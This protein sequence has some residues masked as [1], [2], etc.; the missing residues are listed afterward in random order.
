[1]AQRTTRKLAQHALTWIARIHSHT[2]TNTVTTTLCKGGGA[3]HSTQRKNPA[4]RYHI[5]EEKIQCPRLELN[6]NPPT[7]VI[8]SLGQEHTASDP[9]SY[10][11]LQNHWLSFSYLFPGSKY[12]SNFM[13]CAQKKEKAEMIQINITCNTKLKRKKHRKVVT[14]WK[15]IGTYYKTENMSTLLNACKV[16]KRSIKYKCMCD[17]VHVFHNHTKYDLDR[18]RTDQEIPLSVSSVWRRLWPWTKVKVT[19]FDWLI[20]CFKSSKP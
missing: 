7:L 18:R 1:M 9:L 16:P 10:R 19:G 4:N 17:L 20:D 14:V 15:T 8:S 12:P 11:P 6:P 13:I 5:L 3:N 2:Y